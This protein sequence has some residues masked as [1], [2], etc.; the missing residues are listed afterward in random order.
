MGDILSQSEIDQL[1]HALS[2][3]ELDAEEF[4]DDGAKSV[5]IMILSAR[6]NSP[7]SI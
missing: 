5:K 7:K 4:K 3:G 1:L 2:S 6:R